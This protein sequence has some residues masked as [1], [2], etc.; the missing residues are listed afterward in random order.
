MTSLTQVFCKGVTGRTHTIS[1]DL[2]APSSYFFDSVRAELK[3]PAD[4]DFRIIFRGGEL[5]RDVSLANQ[6][7]RDGCTTHVLGRLFGD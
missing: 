2:N 6:G 5:R 4:V 1:C 7:V 3:I